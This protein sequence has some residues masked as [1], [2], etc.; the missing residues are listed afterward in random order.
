M[1]FRVLDALPILVLRFG[2]TVNK[3]KDNRDGRLGLSRVSGGRTQSRLGEE[4][5]EHR[6]TWPA[7]CEGYLWR[8]VVL[9]N[10]VLPS[11]YRDDLRSWLGAASLLKPGP[12]PANEGRKR[13]RP[14]KSDRK[15]QIA[16]TSQG[17]RACRSVHRLPKP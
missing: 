10:R 14:P 3:V 7:G 6:Q 15:I 8:A 1:T 13:I 9:D 5:L 17:R 4:V 16:C 11:A 2:E 12:K